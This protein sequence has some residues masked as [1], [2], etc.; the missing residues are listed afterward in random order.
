[1]A[2]T[3]PDQVVRLWTDFFNA[4]DLEGLASMYEDDAVLVPAPGEAPVGGVV[5]ILDAW[6]PFIESGAT[7]SIVAGTSIVLGDIALTHN[8]ARVDIPGVDAIEGSSAEVVRLQP[9]GSWKYAICNPYGD[10]H[11]QG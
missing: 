4:R 11:L 3:E 6:K 2:A 9:D 8:R 1:M 5:S 7:M 10:S